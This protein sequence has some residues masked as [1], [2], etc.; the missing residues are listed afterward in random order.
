[1]KIAWGILLFLLAHI[2]TW[3]QLNG[4][5]VWD[6]F[7]N[8][9]FILALFGIPIS[10]LFIIGNRYVVEHFDGVMWPARFVGFGVGV[11]VYAALVWIFFKEGIN[12]KT[13]VSLLLSLTLILIQLFWK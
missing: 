1:M 9:I 8:N 7:K 3:F 2:V 10:Y 6:W 12:L 4:Q 11:I 13:F 5:F